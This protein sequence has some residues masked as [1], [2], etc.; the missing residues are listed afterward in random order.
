MRLFSVVYSLGIR[1]SSLTIGPRSKLKLNR[2][3]FR[4][5]PCLK[6]PSSLEIYCVHN[7]IYLRTYATDGPEKRLATLDA[8]SEVEEKNKDSYL[9]LLHFYKNRDV[10]RRGHVEFIYAALKHMKEFGVHKDLEAY[11][12]LIDVMP[13]GKFVAQ[14]VMQ[15]EF[16]H[17]PKQQQCLIDLLEQME[18]N[19]E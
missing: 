12:K 9:D 6:N 8:F 15:A 10:H 1:C 16:Q 4:C 3:N 17:Y 18:I 13:K 19:G 2:L 7:G 11:K 5:Q 14:N